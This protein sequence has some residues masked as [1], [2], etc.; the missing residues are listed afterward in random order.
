M[1]SS[2]RPT[3]MVKRGG[4]RFNIEYLSQDFKY[5]GLPLDEQMIN[6]ERSEFFGTA[7]HEIGHILGIYTMVNFNI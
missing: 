6:A 7:C 3:G 2:N 4:L 1:D 5:N